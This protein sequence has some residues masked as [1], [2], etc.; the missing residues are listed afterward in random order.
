[1]DVG[2]RVTIES[3]EKQFHDLERAFKHEG[4]PAQLRVGEYYWMPIN[5]DGQKIYLCYQRA[6]GMDYFYGQSSGL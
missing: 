6:V 3:D 4:S 5:E 2:G 1:M